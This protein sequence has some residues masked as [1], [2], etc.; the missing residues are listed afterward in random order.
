M[1]WSAR[2]LA[3][4]LVATALPVS[5][6]VLLSSPAPLK[7]LA[8]SLAGYD[9]LHVGVHRQAFCGRIAAADVAHLVGASAHGTSWSDGDKVPLGSTTDVA[10]EFGCSWTG[11]DGRSISAWVFA[12]P[13]TPA[14]ASSYAA[15]AAAG[16]ARVPGTFGAASV[17]LRCGSS[18]SFRGLFG[19]A[20][21][22]CSVS[23]PQ[24]TADLAGRWCISVVRA[25][26]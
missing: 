17:G 19:D 3:V 1:S 18:Y 12:P 21:L 13:V 7:P 9:T 20:W 8:T 10:H 15:A 25:A 23:G 4:A 24:A 22:V 16:C 5:V 2:L 11:A 6:G 26:S 14:Q